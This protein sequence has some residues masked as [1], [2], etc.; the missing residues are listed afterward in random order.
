MATRL[1]T[2]FCFASMLAALLVAEGALD[3]PFPAP[4]TRQKPDTLIVPM[5]P[6]GG[7]VVEAED[8]APM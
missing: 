4:V 1:M 5:E 3:A 2:P 8:L 6:L 7:L